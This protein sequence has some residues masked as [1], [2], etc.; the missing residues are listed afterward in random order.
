MSRTQTV[1]KGEQWSAARVPWRYRVAAAELPDAVKVL[2]AKVVR[3]TRLWRKEKA[4]V[5]AE[6]IAHFRDAIDAGET[7]ENM[8]DA[9]GDAKEAGQLIGRAKRRNRPLLW[10][11][12]RWSVR[13]VTV[14]VAAYIGLC[15]YFYS[16][17]PTITVDYASRFNQANNALADSDRSWPKLKVLL[18]HWAPPRATARR[19]WN[20]WVYSS[21]G[22][23][24]WQPYKA[25]VRSQQD[26]IAQLR[27]AAMLPRLGLTYSPTVRLLT[28]TPQAGSVADQQAAI[29]S[30]LGTLADLLAG[31]ANV[32]IELNDTDRAVADVLAIEGLAKQLQGERLSAF[33]CRLLLNLRQHLTDTTASLLSNRP[34]FFSDAQLARLAALFPPDRVASD[35]FDLSGERDLFLDGVQ[36]GYTDDG[37]GDGRMTQTGWQSLSVGYSGLRGNLRLTDKILMPVLLFKADKRAVLTERYGKFLGLIEPEFEKPL[38][39]VNTQPL[40]DLLEAWHRD[41]Q[42]NDLVVTSLVGWVLNLQGRAEFGLAEADG[43]ACGIALERYRLSRGAYPADLAAL[44]PAYLT[45]VPRNRVDGQPVRYRLI[46]GKPVVYSVGIGRADNG[47]QVQS[48]TGSTAVNLTNEPWLKWAMPDAVLARLINSSGNWVLYARKSSQKS[49]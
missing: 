18:D 10:H 48:F 13:A 5:A 41:Q 29:I 23:S 25:W 49:N 37:H 20:S 3:S 17:R 9:F 2:I 26:E 15:V 22:D 42:S 32:A 19:A 7:A 24:T 4:A 16:G 38:R 21:P 1:S 36:R 11:A 34:G 47:G 45:R 31:D 28:D 43:V 30:D 33:G 8:I 12:W 35:W 39:D 44:V 46:D 14:L 6:L 40:G 27:Q